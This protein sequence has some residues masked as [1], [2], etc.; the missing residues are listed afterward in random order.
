MARSVAFGCEAPR[1]RRALEADVVNK[2]I[3]ILRIICRDR[4]L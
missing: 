3:A 2:P 4:D 1:L